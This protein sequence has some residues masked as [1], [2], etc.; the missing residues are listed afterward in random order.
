MVIELSSAMLLNS[1]CRKRFGE[2]K[3][4]NS[5]RG[6]HLSFFMHPNVQ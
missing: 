3:G 5:A 6:L 4:S 1:Y 2:A